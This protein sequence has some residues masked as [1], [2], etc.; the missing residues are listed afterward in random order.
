MRI[1]LDGEPFDLTPEGVRSRLMNCQPETVRDYWVE[2]AGTRWPVKQVIA[3]ATGVTD[4]QRFQSQSS[5]RWLTK[6]G[7]P[8][9]RGATTVAPSAAVLSR[10]SPPVAEAVPVELDRVD[11]H[12]GFTWVL[13]GLVTLDAAGLPSFPPLPR[14]PSLYRFDFGEGPDGV[15]T[16]YIGESVELS[17]RASNY[18]NATTDRSRQRT[19]RRIHLELV[20]HL[21]AGGSIQFATASSARWGDHQPLDLRL[22]SARRLAENAAVLLVQSQSG[23]RALNIDT[24][25]EESDDPL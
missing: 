23:M 22:R 12:V 7:F 16:V 17:R 14:V 2:V 9:G 10:P 13:A 6:L 21:Q 18:R 25:I 4:R 5:Q 15:R 8:V 11:V 3:L 20:A 24:D 1:T 19:N